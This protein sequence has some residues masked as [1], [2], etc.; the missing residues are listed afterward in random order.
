[1]CEVSEGGGRREEKK[2][3]GEGGAVDLII[4]D[5]CVRGR[6]C[7]V[8]GGKKYNFNNFASFKAGESGL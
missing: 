2:T 8:G 6:V 5:W 3:G 1:M 7:R 4:T